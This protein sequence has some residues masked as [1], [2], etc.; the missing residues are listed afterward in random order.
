[1]HQDRQPAPRPCCCRAVWKIKRLLVTVTSHDES[2]TISAEKPRKE[3]RPLSQKTEAPSTR[4][5]TYK[6]PDKPWCL[7]RKPIKPP[8]PDAPAHP[9]DR[10]TAPSPP[11]PHA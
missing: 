9:H 7:I 5:A 6:S 8:Q 10:K 1:Q 2:I 4:P 11:R 3:K